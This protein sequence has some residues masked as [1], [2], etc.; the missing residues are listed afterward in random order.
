MADSG[1]VAAVPA[2]AIPKEVAFRLCEQ[3]REENRGKWYRWTAWMCW[4]CTT[5][6]KDDMSR[7]CVGSRSDHR[8]CMQVCARFAQQKG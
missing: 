6:C 4:G 3:I 8:G 5:F 2:D 1:F 7:M